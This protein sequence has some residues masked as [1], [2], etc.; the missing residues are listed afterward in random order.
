MMGLCT[1]LQGL[2]WSGERPVRR[3][4]VTSSAMRSR[5]TN[6]KLSPTW[7][8]PR[9][10]PASEFPV[11]QYILSPDAQSSNPSPTTAT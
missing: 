3:F 11:P 9:C 7:T 2:S 8:T 5:G 1:E 4:S 10:T 6:G